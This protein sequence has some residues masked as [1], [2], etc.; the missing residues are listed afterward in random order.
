MGLDGICGQRIRQCQKPAPKTK[1][2]VFHINPKT[3]LKG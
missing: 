2:P 3:Y 1:C